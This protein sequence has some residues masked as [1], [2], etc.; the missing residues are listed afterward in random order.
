MRISMDEFEK[1]KSSSLFKRVTPLLSSNY[2]YFSFLGVSGEKYKD[3]AVLLIEETKDSYQGDLD[4][5]DFFEVQLLAYL[6]GYFKKKYDDN[7]K[8]EKVIT[9]ALNNHFKNDDYKN[10]CMVVKMFYKLVEVYGIEDPQGLLFNL[11]DKD[12]ALN[13]SLK[14]IYE[15]NK[16]VI[17]NGKIENNI[18]S[19]LIISC[20]EAYCIKNHIEINESL[21]DDILNYKFLNEMILLIKDINQYPILTKEQE[22]SLGRRI[23]NGDAAAK[24]L[25]VNSN[26]RL[27]LSIAKRYQNRGL[28]LLDLF[29]HGCLGLLKAADRYDIDKG[30]RFSTYATWWIKQSVQR[31]IADEA[32]TIRIPVHVQEK[33]NNFNTKIRLLKQ[34]LGREPTISEI[35]IDQKL[36]PKKVLLYLKLQVEPVSINKNVNENNDEPTELG[37]FISSDENVEDE[38]INN[39]VIP[40]IIDILDSYPKLDKRAT[41]I[42]IK[43]FNLDGNGRKTLEEIGQLFNISRERVR[44]IEAKTL[45]ILNQ[46]NNRKKLD[47]YLVTSSK[48]NEPVEIEEDYKVSENDSIDDLI[49]KMLSYMDKINQRLFDDK[50]VAIYINSLGIYDGINKSYEDLSKIYGLNKETIARICQKLSYY[51]AHDDTLNSILKELISRKRY[52]DEAKRKTIEKDF[53]DAINKIK[54]DELMEKIRIDCNLQIKAK[55]FL[56]LRYGLVD[57]KKRSIWDLITYYREPYSKIE[58]TI[59][60][61]IEKIKEH[62]GFEEVLEKIDNYKEEE[63]MPRKTTPIYK[64]IG[65]TKE[66]LVN[67]LSV[68]DEEEIE[69]FKKRNGEDL[70]NP[71]SILTRE[72]SSKFFE[73]VRVLKESI[74]NPN[75]KRRNKNKDDKKCEQ[76]FEKEEIIENKNEVVEVKKDFTKEDYLS[77]LKALKTPTMKELLETLPEDVAI[78]SMLR[79]GYFNGK[80]FSTESIS[81]FLDVPED[82]V[83]EA[84]TKSLVVYKEKINSMVDSV[85]KEEEKNKQM[86]IKSRNNS[87]N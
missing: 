36:S 24:E 83:K 59:N 35:S 61:A 71:I 62:G 50:K 43:R 2:K 5:E 25:M 63:D 9:S 53:R 72:E 23:K 30:F 58:K 85:V 4:Y 39:Q 51:I 26:L 73:V 8:I 31:G 56:G 33:I 37:Y 15:K 78:I 28:E 29:Q 79:L 76:S 27:V 60:I 48:L 87:A 44:Q 67:A 81:K 32:K 68:L 10:A 84:F 80:Y 77:V 17:I 86:L 22:Q 3:L 55:T 18:K 45:G 34:S 21:D 49:N 54:K 75:Y 46:P 40:I 65:C 12:N 47:E 42:I 19:Q 16:N 52:R 66:E 13:K 11:L 74:N 14:I 64:I 82:Y 20:I 41:Q 69:L 1:T 6:K 57:G 38:V 7:E 70:D